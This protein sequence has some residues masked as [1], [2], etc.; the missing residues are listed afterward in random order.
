M[1]LAPATFELGRSILTCL[2]ASAA[3]R[4]RSVLHGSGAAGE[5]ADRS[6]R[7]PGRGQ[8]GEGR[9]RRRV[10]HHEVGQVVQLDRGGPGFTDHFEARVSDRL[11]IAV[12][13]E[14]FIRVDDAPESPKLAE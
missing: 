5:H 12:C 10:V 3:S 13:T 14:N 2:S 6:D 11:G 8:V 1:A 4:G 9:A 7:G